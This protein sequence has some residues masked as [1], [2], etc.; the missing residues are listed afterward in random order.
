MTDE[1]QAVS[2]AGARIIETE[3]LLPKLKRF[4]RESP[5]LLTARSRRQCAAGEAGVEGNSKARASFSPTVGAVLILWC[6]LQF[7]SLANKNH[8]IRDGV[9][10]VC[11]EDAR[12]RAE[13]PGRRRY[14]L[15]W[16]GHRGHG[17]RCRAG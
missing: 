1:Q 13:R 14:C 15:Q 7:A 17:Y 9:G 11:S 8:I 6:K 16:P 3:I 10:D 5:D 12:P 2:M 4:V